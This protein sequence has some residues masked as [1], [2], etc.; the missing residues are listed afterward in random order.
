MDY[1]PRLPDL[2]EAF[3]GFRLE[4]YHK[5]GAKYRLSQ[6]KTFRRGHVTGNLLRADVDGSPI[7]VTHKFTV[8]YILSIMG[9]SC[10]LVK[11]AIKQGVRDLVICGLAGGL[12]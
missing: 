6:G 1:L 9:Q 7:L 12:S 11:M 3:I 2:C 8:R 10:W 5:T 4:C